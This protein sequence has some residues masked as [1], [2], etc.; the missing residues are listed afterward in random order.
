MNTGIPTQNSRSQAVVE[1]NT[2]TNSASK[3]NDAASSAQPA[4]QVVAPPV[5]PLVKEQIT[6]AAEQ[7]EKPSLQEVIEIS[8]RLQDSVQTIRRDLNFSVD[9][10]L[11]DIVITVTDRETQETIRQIPSEE[12]LSISRNIEEVKSLLFDKIKA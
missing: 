5:N 10:T 11:G 9:E 3:T 6:A 4:Q 2:S 12:V 8:A 1:L 7:Q